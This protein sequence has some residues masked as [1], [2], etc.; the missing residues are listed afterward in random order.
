MDLLLETDFPG[1]ILSRIRVFAGFPIVIA[2][3]TIYT[4]ACSISN[5]PKQSWLVSLESISVP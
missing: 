1:K 2:V 4:F 3:M 5:F